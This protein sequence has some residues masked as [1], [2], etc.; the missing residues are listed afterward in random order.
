MTTHDPDCELCLAHRLSEWFYEDE[1]CWVAACIVCST[2]MVVW[3][4][5]GLPDP[6]TE[7]R[8][9]G[10]L[11][12]VADETFGAGAWWTDA[13]RRNIPD[14]WHCHARPAGGFFG[15]GVVRR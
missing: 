5:H 7:E 14:H 6:D 15:A 8:L 9:L 4:F 11:A 1:E 10:R 2:P 13:R 3:R 12:P